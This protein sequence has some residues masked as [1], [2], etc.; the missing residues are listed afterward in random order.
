[1]RSQKG[2]TLIELLV[3]VAI[4]GVLAAIV[5]VALSDAKNK[6]GDAGVQANLNT[7]RG[8][9]ELFY[10]SNSNAFLPSG[11]STLAI[12]TCPT[13]SA[14]GTNMM[15]KDQAIANAIAQAVKNGGGSSACY[16]SST[17]WAVAVVLKS[18]GASSTDTIPDT[19]CVDSS[20]ASK[21]YTWTSGQTTA[22]NSINVTACR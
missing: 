12:G 22:S 7:I 11:G 13:Y 8:E 17:A 3:V 20:G 14:S 1:M 18:G 19:W 16:N 9:S 10:S 5:M 21:S 15:A 6:G 4:I 2:F